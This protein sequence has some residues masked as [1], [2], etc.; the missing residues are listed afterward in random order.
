MATP[1]AAIATPRVGPD[2]RG[3]GTGS[4]DRWRT[5]ASGVEPVSEDP[6]PPGPTIEAA[7][8]L[9]AEGRPF[10]AHEVFEARW[11]AAPTGERDLWQ[12][13]AQLCVGSTHRERGNA[14]GARTLWQR[15]LGRL[16]TYAAT[17]QPTYGLD[18]DAITAWLTRRLGELDESVVSGSRTATAL[19]SA[20]DGAD[21]KGVGMY[22]FGRSDST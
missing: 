18:L 14:R 8:A 13:L 12:G 19:S 7:R 15:A 10:S 3:P 1:W 21:Q 9:L 6:L 17:D 4:A 20:G 5:G 2:R 22:F 16:T 11:K